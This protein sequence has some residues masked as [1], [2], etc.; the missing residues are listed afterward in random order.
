MSRSSRTPKAFIKHHGQPAHG[1]DIVLGSA[2]VKADCRRGKQGWALPGYGFTTCPITAKEKALEINRLIYANGGLPA[3][4][5][6]HAQV[7]V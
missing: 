2:T 1:T 4:A 3:W 5:A 7:A 6:K